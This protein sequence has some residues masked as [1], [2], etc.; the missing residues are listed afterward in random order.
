MKP[1]MIL[2]K[3]GDSSKSRD[4][5]NIT[6]RCSVCG[7]EYIMKWTDY[8]IDKGCKFDCEYCHFKGVVEPKLNILNG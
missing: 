1:K 8:E 6:L 3:E 2:T 4:K 5:Y 7:A